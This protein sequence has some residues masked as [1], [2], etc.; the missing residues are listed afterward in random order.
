MRGLKSKPLATPK[1][2]C[3][4]KTRIIRRSPGSA[5]ESATGFSSRR[6]KNRN[7]QDEIRYHPITRNRSRDLLLRQRVQDQVDDE[8]GLHIEVCSPATRS[9]P[10]SRRSSTPPAAS[11]SSTEVRCA[12]RGKA[13]LIRHEFRGLEKRQPEAAAFFRL[14]RAQSHMPNSRTSASRHPLPRRA[15]LAIAR[16]RIFTRR[17]DRTRSVETTTL[18]IT[19]GRAHASPAA[20]WLMPQLAGPP[21]P[22]APLYYWIAA[23]TAKLFSWLLPDGMTHPPAADLFT[24]WP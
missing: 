3:K 5:T 20:D 14:Y 16:Y 1:P 7:F 24:C 13:D 2:P 11:R 4:K 19:I 12:M 17:P 21:F 18:P 15:G 8:E 23:L 6:L 9:T 22:D 10:A